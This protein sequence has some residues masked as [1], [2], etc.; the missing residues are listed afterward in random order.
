MCMNWCSHLPHQNFWTV[1]ISVSNGF[2]QNIY[3]YHCPKC[4]K[5]MWRK[6]VSKN[7][8]KSKIKKKLSDT[9]IH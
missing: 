7:N 5:Y 9:L 2:R 6:S 1:Q 8:K 4:I 3:K